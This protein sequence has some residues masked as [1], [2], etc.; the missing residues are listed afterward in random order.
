MKELSKIEFLGLTFYNVT[1]KELLTIINDTIQNGNSIKIFT[2]NVALLMWSRKDSYLSGVYK[3]CDILTVDGY[4]IYYA[5]KLLNLPIKATLSPSVFYHPLI[6]QA[7]EK[8]YKIYLVGAREG[9][10]KKNVENLSEMYPGINI[11]GFHNGYFD[12]TSPPEEL[13]EDIKEKDVDLLL[14]GMSS[15]LKEK[16]VEFLMEETN[17]KVYIGVGGMF[18]I[19]AGETQYAPKWMRVL[20]LEWLYRLSQEPRRLI[21]RYLT[22]NSKFLFL[23]LKEIVRKYALKG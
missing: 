22:T 6:E 18:D 13:I 23:L 14:V 2:P 8:K 7:T 5:M 10:V 4:A 11:V 17:T 3:S 1:M 12:V 21:K 19:I 15:P 20:A 16:L 9:V